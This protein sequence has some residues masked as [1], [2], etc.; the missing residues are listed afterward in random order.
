MC[1]RRTALIASA[2]TRIPNDGAK[3]FCDGRVAIATGLM[4]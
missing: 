3:H 1:E 4:D 2:F